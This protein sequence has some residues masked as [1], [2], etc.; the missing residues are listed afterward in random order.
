[1]SDPAPYGMD[2]QVPSRKKKQTLARSLNLILSGVGTEGV[3]ISEM[4]TETE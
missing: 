2:S 1:M 3:S 4:T